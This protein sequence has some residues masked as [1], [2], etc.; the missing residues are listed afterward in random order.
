MKV[1]FHNIKLSGFKISKKK[2][3]CIYDDLYFLWSVKKQQHSP[4]RVSNLRPMGCL[5]PRMAVNEAQHK[6]VNLLKTLLDFVVIT[7][8]SV[9]NVWPKT[10]LLLPEW[11]RD[12]KRLDTPEYVYKGGPQTPA[13][14]YKKFCVYSYTFKLQSPS[15]YSPFHAIHLSGHFFFH[16]LEQ[17]LNTLTLMPFSASAFFVSLLPHQQNVSLWG[18]FSSGET[19]KKSH[20]GLDQVNR[21]FGAYRLCC[22]GSKTAGHSARFGQ[23]YL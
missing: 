5:Q 13:F 12:A 18:F 23:V 17:F 9:V 20:P 21:E 7:C 14:I 15:K 3:V 22:L 16:R 6:I 2:V 4:Y 8:C 1:F 10:T 11:Y 19:N